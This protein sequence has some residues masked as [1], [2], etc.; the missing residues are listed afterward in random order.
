MVWLTKVIKR[1]I[2]LLALILALLSVPITALASDISGA[3]HRGLILVSNNSTATS[4]VATI[5]SVNTTNLINLGYLNAGATNAVVRNTSGADVE[6]MPGYTPGGYPWCFWVPTIGDYGVRTYILYTAESTGG[7]YSYFP[8]IDGMET[9][10]DADLEP[11]DNYT[12]EQSGW[13]DTDAGAGKNLVDK[14]GAVSVY[15]SPTVSGNITVQI[16]EYGSPTGHTDGGGTWANETKAYDGN[17]TT[18]ANEN[19]I[20]TTSWGNYLELTRAATTITGVSIWATAQNAAVNKVDIDFYYGGGWNN[21][22]EADWDWGEW[23]YI[24]HNAQDVTNIRVRFYNSDGGTTYDAY[25][26]ELAYGIPCQASIT[27]VTSGKYTV[28]AAMESPFL[29]IGVDAGSDI[30]PVADNLQL[31]D[32]LWQTDCEGATFDSIDSN[33]LTNTVTGADW[34]SSGYIFTD[35][36]DDNI[37][38]TDAA[39]IQNVFD[40]GGSFEFWANIDGVDSGDVV[41]SKNGKWLVFL[42]TIASGKT[43]T[44]FYIDFSGTDGYFTSVDGLTI[45]GWTHYFV[46]LADSNAGTIPIMYF[47]GEPS[48]VNVNANS[49]GTRVSDAG[50]DLMVG[51]RPD[52]AKDLDGI[53]GELRLYGRVLTPA[54]IEQNYDATKFKYTS[55]GDTSLQ[56]TLVSVP[57]TSDNWTFLENNVMPYMEYQEITVGGAQ[58]QYIEW[59][60]GDTFKDASGEGHDATPSFRSASS[61]ADVSANMTSFMPISESRAPAYVLGEAPA[62]IDSDALTENITGTFTTTPDTGSGTFPLADVIKSIAD[63]TG[64]PAQL[65]LLIIAAFVIFAGSIYTSWLFRKHGSGSLVVKIVAILALMGIFVALGNFA[66]DFWMIVVFVVFAVAIAFASKQLGWT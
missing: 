63:A 56:S 61:D 49:V 35:G 11:G 17:V 29:G 58:Q 24:E 16:G 46:T 37:N 31:N 4:N 34:S 65:P 54:E 23:N 57:D 8:D 45:N 27:G 53:I 50:N 6:F 25:L 42:N 3:L 15:V 60:Y 32:P 13:I 28:V 55:Y 30:L 48:T 43:R 62:F 9:A 41:A 38:I 10:D 1:N 36:D 40:G 12:I 44:S 14:G 51:N 52:L 66:F 39:A 21:V 19:N 47:N 2:I 33:E 20:P 59:E 26:Y 64:T 5:A 7:E 18:Y 22:Y